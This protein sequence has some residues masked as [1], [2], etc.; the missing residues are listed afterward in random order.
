MPVGLLH[1]QDGSPEKWRHP[2]E[3]MTDL[4]FEMEFVIEK[5]HMPFHKWLQE[6]DEETR[7][8]HYTWYRIHLARES[9][10]SVP[11]EERFTFFARKV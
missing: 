9:Y 4:Y 10:W 7:I 2:M 3:R 1:R 8:L 11:K 5:L 6:T